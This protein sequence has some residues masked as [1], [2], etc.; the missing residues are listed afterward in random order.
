MPVA[1]LQGVACTSTRILKILTAIFNTLMDVA[2]Y[3]WYETFILNVMSHPAVPFRDT[4]CVSRKGRV[5][6]WVHGKVADRQALGWSWVGHF[7][8]CDCSMPL[9]GWVWCS[10]VIG[11]QCFH[12]APV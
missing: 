5:H 9:D 1:V 7:E 8:S 3:R 12:C 6:G 2:G 11:I 4:F 10:L